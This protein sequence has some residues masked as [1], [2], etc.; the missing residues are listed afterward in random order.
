MAFNLL[1]KTGPFRLRS[2][3]IHWR[4]ISTSKK[5]HEIDPLDQWIASPPTHTLTDSLNVDHLSDLYITLPTRDGS[6]KP[7]QEPQPGTPL[8][9]GHHLAFF[10]A[11]KPESLLRIDGTDEEFS[12]PSP[13][14]KRMWAGG[15]M[16]W[17]T[18]NPLI[19]GKR[20]KSV[21]TVMSAEKKGFEK[22]NPMV[23]V[24]QN[25]QF[26]QEGKQTPSVTEERAHVY[27]NPEVSLK[28]P[29][30]F[31]R[32]VQGIPSTVDFTFSYTPSSTTLFRYSALTFNA[33]HIHL[34]KE[35]CQGEEGYPECLVHGPLT[36]QMLL[37]S[38]TF[39]FPQVQF[40][41]FEYRAT[42]AMFVNRTLTIKGTWVDDQT[43]QL[44][45]CDE[46]IV[47]MV[48][49]LKVKKTGA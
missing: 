10:H 2:S 35:Y 15:K 4:T 18:S 28:Q 27:F 23:F 29:K 5:Q 36:A 26:T 39:H 21:S 45:C 37:E 8:P 19:I 12:P 42:N 11:R 9:F 22:G 17:D 38:V 43:I 31:D 33:H 1:R 30:K 25:I 49:F 3:Q 40:C 20:T 44:W 7:Y 32:E 47:G 14:S 41:H 46:N 34:N 13:F 6:R 24:T 48:A 16:T